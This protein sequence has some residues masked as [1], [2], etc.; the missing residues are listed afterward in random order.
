MQ[1]KDLNQIQVEETNIA[2]SEDVERFKNIVEPGN[3]QDMG[4][5]NIIN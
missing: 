5:G 2:W 1:T 4:N 3:W